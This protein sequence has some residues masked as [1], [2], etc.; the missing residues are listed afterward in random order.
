MPDRFSKGYGSR[1]SMYEKLRNRFDIQH[2][3]LCTVQ[4]R[5]SELMR[6][7]KDQSDQLP[8]HISTQME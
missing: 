5:Q 4:V 3:L 1:K 2:Y 6:V 7:S 8:D